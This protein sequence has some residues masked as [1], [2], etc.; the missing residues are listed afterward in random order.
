MN[1]STT[2]YHFMKSYASAEYKMSISAI[3]SGGEG[4]AIQ[5]RFVTL[6][7]G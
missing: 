2:R 7:Q 5:C 6:E 1:S 3:S 4:S